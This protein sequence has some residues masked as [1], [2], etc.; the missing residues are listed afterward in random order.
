MSEYVL[1]EQ[2]EQDLND[3]WDYIADQS[4]DHTDRPVCDRFRNPCADG[5]LGQLVFDRPE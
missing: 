5:H 1:T 4:I 3:I 2:A